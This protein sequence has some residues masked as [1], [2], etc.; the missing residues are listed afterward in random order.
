MKMGEATVNSSLDSVLICS[1]FQLTVS[2]Q[3][4]NLNKCCPLMALESVL[5]LFTFHKEAQLMSWRSP[6][7]TEDNF[8]DNFS[9]SW[10][11]K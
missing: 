11:Q 2:G 8:E 10:L 3:I 7:R 9:L 6:E 4:L 5:G 1:L